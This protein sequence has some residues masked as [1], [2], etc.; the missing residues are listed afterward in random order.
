[1]HDEPPPRRL[2]ERTGI[3]HCINCLAETPDEEYFANDHI[4]AKCAE[5][6]S[7][8]RETTSESPSSTTG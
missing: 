3:H 2:N 5:K 4:C 1:M 7:T 8:A 6:E